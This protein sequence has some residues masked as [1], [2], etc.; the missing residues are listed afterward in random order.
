MTT[1]MP[2]NAATSTVG[3]KIRDTFEALARIFH[4]LAAFI[5]QAFKGAAVQLVLQALDNAAYGSLRR[6]RRGNIFGFFLP[7]RRG[8]NRS[9]GSAAETGANHKDIMYNFDP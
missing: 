7:S 2:A 5:G 6:A 3:L 4:V 8:T 1:G 9:L